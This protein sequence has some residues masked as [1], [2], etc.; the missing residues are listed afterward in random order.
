MEMVS[1]VRE[2]Q[3]SEVGE[4]IFHPSVLKGLFLVAI[5]RL[6]ERHIA[7]GGCGDNEVEW[8]T[9]FQTE[10]L[11][12]PMQ[13]LKRVVVPAEP[14][15]VLCHGDFNRNNLLFRYDDGG[16]PVD[17]LAYDM[18]TIRYGSPV[19]DLSFFL[20]MN[21]DRRIRDDHWDTLLDVYCAALAAVIGDVP[22]P[23]LDRDQLDAEIREYGFYGLVHVSYFARVMLEEGPIEQAD[24]FYKADELQMLN[25]LV[26]NGGDPATEWVADA[27]QHFIRCKYARTP[28]ANEH[29]IS[30]EN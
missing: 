18:A 7:G 20:Y 13:S 28:A 23:L 26:S 30:V 4:W 24:E 3:W 22:V 10:L 25:L 27:I 1:Q 19:L 6:K 12:D 9:R 5:E 15:A 11:A 21:T 29:D 16:R 14:I 2:T 8:I 17:G